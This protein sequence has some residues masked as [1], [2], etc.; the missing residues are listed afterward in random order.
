MNGVR[1]AYF[2]KLS[3]FRQRFHRPRNR[4]GM[5]VLVC[6]VGEIPPQLRRMKI[7][8]LKP[9]ERGGE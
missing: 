2:W 7:L 3:K 1:A 6:I 5:T 9:A 4:S 8:R